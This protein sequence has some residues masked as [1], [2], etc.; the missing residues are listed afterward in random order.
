MPIVQ[1]RCANPGCGSDLMRDDVRLLNARTGKPAQVRQWPIQIALLLVCL[2]ALAGVQLVRPGAVRLA[3]DVAVVVT[4]AALSLA[5]LTLLARPGI[6]ARLVP[7]LHL[8]T[9]TCQ[10]CG[11]TWQTKADAAPPYRAV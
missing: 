10:I 5:V 2:V 11:Y 1:I 7:S 8:H 3:L 9:Y 6:I 4:C